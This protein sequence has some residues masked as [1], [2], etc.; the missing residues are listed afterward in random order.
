MIITC[1]RKYNNYYAR[2]LVSPDGKRKMA[3]N[4]NSFSSGGGA[5]AE[6]P[7]ARLKNL[8]SFANCSRQ[9]ETASKNFSIGKRWS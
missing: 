4:A 8:S 9:P 5:T 7:A 3:M 6:A 2:Q 1:W